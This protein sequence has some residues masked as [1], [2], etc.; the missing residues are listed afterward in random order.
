MSPLAICKPVTMQFSSLRYQTD[1][2]FVDYVHSDEQLMLQKSIAKLF[3]D[4]VSRTRFK[5]KNLLLLETLSFKSRTPHGKSS[6]QDGIKSVSFSTRILWN[7]LSHL[8]ALCHI[9]LNQK[10]FTLSLH[11]L[12]VVVI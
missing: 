12:V 10:N 7:P 11:T 3:Y 4:L 8:S 9:K 1:E 6:K 5:G 2:R